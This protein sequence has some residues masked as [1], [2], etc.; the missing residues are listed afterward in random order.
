MKKIVITVILAAI[1]VAALVWA[2][3]YKLS[4]LAWFPGFLVAVFCVI[5]IFE[6]NQVWQN[7]VKTNS[8]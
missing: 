8:R 4:G 2:C 5:K 6:I 7:D 3:S 1:A